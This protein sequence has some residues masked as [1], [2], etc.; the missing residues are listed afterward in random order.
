MS[1]EYVPQKG[2][3][4]LGI[5]KRVCAMTAAFIMSVGVFSGFAEES[6]QPSADNNENTETAAEPSEDSGISLDDAVRELEEQQTGEQTEEQEPGQKPAVSSRETAPSNE[7][8][9]QSLSFSVAPYA[10]KL[11]DISEKQKTLEDKLKLYEEQLE[12]SD[13]TTELYME[14]LSNIN[15]RRDV[16][17][18]Y[19]TRLEISINDNQSLLEKKQKEIDRNIEAFKKRLRAL[20]LSG[21]D[22]SYIN[23]LLGS[24]DLYDILMRMELVKRIAKHDDEFIDALTRSKQELEEIQESLDSQQKDYNR[25]IST[26]DDLQ[27]TY[28]SLL[29]HHK[30]VREKIEEQKKQLEEQNE[31][32]IKERN[33]YGL[34]VINE[35]AGEGYG[36]SANDTVRLAAE[37]QA[38]AA[39]KTLYAIIEQRRSAGTLG[40]GDCCYVFKWPVDG[41][42]YVS[43]G[44][45]ARWGKYHSGIDIPADK[46]TPIKVCESG[47]VVKTFTECPHD[48][49]KTESCG[50]GGGYG[51]FVLVDHGNGFMTLYG[52]MTRVD[53]KPGDK[54]TKGEVIGGMGSTG[55]STGDHLHLEIRYNGTPINPAAF[56]TIN[57]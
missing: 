15:E 3:S 42:Y 17:N 45:G 34:G 37:L 1:F 50:C 55:F 48:Y 40:E 2:G 18:S 46:G 27:R 31:A 41:H 13:E 20:Y 8:E 38:K 54:V 23:V 22:E 26:L 9:R 21:G 57:G 56:V 25:Q 7:N 30:E 29:A 6:E 5:S 10:Q 14:Y 11:M 52:H 43:S 47:T 44:V 32:Y 49:G 35:E 51:N 28:D 33:Q 12:K 4:Y 36:T 16:V 24:T 39:L 19:L 53:V